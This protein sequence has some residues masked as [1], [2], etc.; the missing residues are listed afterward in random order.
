M[1]KIHFE[2]RRS[3]SK[4]EPFF[5]RLVAANGQKYCHSETFTQKASA[6]ASINNIIKAIGVGA[7]TINDK[8]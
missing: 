2:I 1:R 6:R 7:V 5:W 4:A 3:T 8:S